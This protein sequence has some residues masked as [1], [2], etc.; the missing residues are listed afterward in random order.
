LH[1]RGAA[2]FSGVCVQVVYPMGEVSTASFLTLLNNI[3]TGVYLIVTIY[4]SPPIMN[5]LLSIC[6][7]ACAIALLFFKVRAQ[8]GAALRCPASGLQCIAIWA[9]LSC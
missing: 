8:R 2:F 6:C 9:A 3:S 7:G 4:I 5:W 1:T